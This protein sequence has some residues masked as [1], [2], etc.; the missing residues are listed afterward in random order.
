MDGR[1][2]T[3]II[4]SIMIIILIVTQYYDAEQEF[5][6]AF[7]TMVIQFGYFYFYK[8]TF[9]YIFYPCIFY[10]AILNCTFT[11]DIVLHILEI[12][13][14][15]RL[16]RSNMSGFIFALFTCTQRMDHIKRKIKPTLNNVTFF[17]FVLFFPPVLT[18][19][20]SN[21]KSRTTSEW[22]TLNINTD[23]YNRAQRMSSYLF[24]K[25]ENSSPLALIR[26]Y[27]YS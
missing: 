6:Y 5:A 3:E 2:R 15:Y 26:T 12:C 19:C 20:S 7:L 21:I 13:F 14:L 18:T 9:A 24:T 23:R 27:I 1:E 25:K 17:L 16:S 8:A 11:L 22:N 4:I 10:P